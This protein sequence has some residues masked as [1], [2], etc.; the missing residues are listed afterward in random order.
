MRDPERIDTVLA[1][2]R[3]YWQAYP[4]LR[5]GQLILNAVPE[6]VLYYREDEDLVTAL[7]SVYGRSN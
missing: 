5:L 7:D 4:D 6:A 1:V 3:R 2:I